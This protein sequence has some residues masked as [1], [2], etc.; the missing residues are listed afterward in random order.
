MSEP[1]WPQEEKAEN[2]SSHELART[3]NE[4]GN[5]WSVLKLA[6]RGAG[7][8]HSIIVEGSVKCIAC[9]GYTND[10]LI[11]SD[12]RDGIRLI[13]SAGNINVLRKIIEFFDAPGMLEVIKL[14]TDDV[15]GE[16][17]MKRIEDAR[18]R[19]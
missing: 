13:R 6:N 17:M 4:E 9:A 5:T 10:T 14:L 1:S 7:V 12:C 18:N 11:C 8:P 19:D 3:R 2:S 16:L 15:V